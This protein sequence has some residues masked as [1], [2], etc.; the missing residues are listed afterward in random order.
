MTNLE[1]NQELT[2]ERLQKITTEITTQVLRE[3]GIQ[4]S[5]GMLTTQEV[6]DR[7]GVSINKVLYAVDT[8]ELRAIRVSSR[9]FRYK[10]EDVEACEALWASTDLLDKP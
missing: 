3:L 10:L 1:T 6:S 2:V 8:G 5:T 9:L 4:P 7:W